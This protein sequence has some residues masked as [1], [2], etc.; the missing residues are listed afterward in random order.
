ME[1]KLTSWNVNSVR[2]RLDAVN[3]WAQENR[4]QILCLQE[5]KVQDQDYPEVLPGYERVLYGQKTY[6]GVS[7]HSLLPIREIRRGLP[8][9][10]INLQKRAVTAVTDYFTVVNVYIPQGTSPDSPKFSY[11]LD[12]L[13]SL[14]DYLKTL[15]PRQNRVVLAGDFNI[16]A[17]ERDLFEPQLFRNQVLFHPEELRRFQKLR[18]LG[19]YD[20]LR[21]FSEEAGI[22]S[23]WDYRG[24]AFRRGLGIRL[25]YI[26]ISEALKSCC[27]SAGTDPQE[28]R[29]EKASDHIPVNAVFRF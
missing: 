15:L 18:E 29:K 9:E 10:E 13:D 19:F 7:I 6:N 14:T 3:R 17:D 16:A 5:T 22:Y 4:P 11:K 21:L 8:G 20:S 27:I 1:I 23:W 2:A 26:W 24:G 25:D 12:F 28:R